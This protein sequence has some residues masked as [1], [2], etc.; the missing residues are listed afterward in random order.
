MQF[1][2]DRT[3]SFDD[4]FSLQNEELQDEAYK[5]LVKSIC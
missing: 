3:V 5:K 1:I 4:Y 2:K